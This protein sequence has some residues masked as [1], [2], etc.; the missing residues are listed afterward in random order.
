MY[1]ED[2]PDIT[3]F[4]SN[5]KGFRYWPTSFYTYPFWKKYYEIRSGPHKCHYNKPTYMTW[6]EQIKTFVQ[7]A[8]SAGTKVPYFSFSFLTEYTHDDLAVPPGLDEQ[9]KNLLVNLQKEGYLDNTMLIVL[10]D[11]GNRLQKY[12]FATSNGRTERYMP[13]LSI[14]LPKKFIGTSFHK[15]ALINKYRLVT[16]FD[17]HQTL[18]HFLFMNTFDLNNF[19]DKSCKSQFKKNA[20]YQRNLRGISLFHHIP[21]NRTCSDALISEEFC[22]CYKKVDVEEKVFQTET[23]HSFNSASMLAIRFINNLTEHVRSKCEPFKLNKV[24]SFRKML[25]SEQVNVYTEILVLS[26]GDAWF[27]VT[28]KMHKGSLILNDTPIRLSAYGNQ[29]K[30]IKDDPFLPSYCFCKN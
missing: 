13:F 30:C 1:Q 3:L 22:N 21:K 19:K 5:K 10:S 8:N 4:N 9:L 17:V 27:D 2:A 29:A 26:P 11:H 25:Y 18:R 15:R 20:I 14:K 28:F 6:L 24:V 23:S 16:L 12:S 7:Q